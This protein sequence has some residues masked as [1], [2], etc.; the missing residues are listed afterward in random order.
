MLLV[1]AEN[2][3][4]SSEDQHVVPALSACDALAAAAVQQAREEVERIRRERTLRDIE[5][6]STTLH[7]QH[8]A[9]VC[10]AL[11]NVGCGRH[12]VRSAGSC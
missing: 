12:T 9:V 7:I 11:F 5:S 3:L 8:L 10:V 1:R 6:W 2:S 4:L